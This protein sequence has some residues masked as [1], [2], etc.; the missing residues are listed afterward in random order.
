M[1]Q[2][3]KLGKLPARQDARNLK[4]AKYLGVTI[5]PAPS[6]CDWIKGK[7]GFGMMLNDQ[8][9]DCAIAAP[10]H[11]EQ[12]WTLN[13]SQ[14]VTIPDRDILKAYE[15]VSGYKPS[16]PN[17][18]NGCNMLDVLKYWRTIGIGGRKIGAF[19]EIDL[20]TFA[21]VKQA[22]YLFGGIYI[23][24]QL[25][26]SAERQSI[27]KY[28]GD[29]KG[30]WGGHAVEVVRYDLNYLT[31]ITW[32]KPLKMTQ[33]FFQF[34]CDEAYAVLSNDWLTVKGIAPNHFNMAQLQIDLSG[35]Q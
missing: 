13:A 1:L 4:L 18:D 35:I 3:R 20:H 8:L 23:G 33:E 32:G 5:P 30:G 25:P 19:T 34:Y 24:L 26:T 11:Q 27:W 28:V 22:I 6:T 16:D 9:G 12:V 2:Q 17:T 15:A 14:E 10:A 29:A 31:C 7:G 21:H